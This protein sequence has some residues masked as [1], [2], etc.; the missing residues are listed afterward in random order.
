MSIR[1]ELL[2]YLLK[3][4]YEYHTS[5]ELQ[6]ALNK[7]GTKCSRSGVD[8]EIGYIRYALEPQGVFNVANKPTG[9]HSTLAYKYTGTIANDASIP[10]LVEQYLPEIAKACQV[11]KAIKLEQ[12]ALAGVP[13]TIKL[14]SNTAAL[15]PAPAT[16]TDVTQTIRLKVH[17]DVHFS[18][19]LQED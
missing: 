3:N 1:T 4:R 16:P 6:T 15:T 14:A 2:T 10:G 19:K 12:K 9:N 8:L 11:V 7:A 5:K 13:R 17:V 18:V